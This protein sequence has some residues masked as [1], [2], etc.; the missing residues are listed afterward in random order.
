M[1]PTTRYYELGAH[2]NTVRIRSVTK[3]MLTDRGAKNLTRLY[4][5]TVLSVVENVVRRDDSAMF[6]YP[7]G[8]RGR[9][10]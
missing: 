5:M 4:W 9:F 3:Q 10:R 1:D 8:A 6:R 7:V 2:E